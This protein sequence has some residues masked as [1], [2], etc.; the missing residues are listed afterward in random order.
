VR[1]SDNTTNGW[2]AR[3]VRSAADWSASPTVDAVL[4]K[5]GKVV[6]NDGYYGTNAPCGWIAI[7]KSG[8]G[9]MS[10]AVIW[11]NDTCTDTFSETLKQTLVCQEMGHALGLGDHRLD[12]PAIPSCMA[13]NHQGP[14]PNQDDFDQLA[15]DYP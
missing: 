8:Q 12:T 10:N 15:A 6:V 4:G 2:T 13:P 1:F 11:I 14:S 7:Y 3:L 5:S 9:F